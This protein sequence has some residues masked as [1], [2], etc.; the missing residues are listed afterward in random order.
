MS[1]VD[2]RAVRVSDAAAISEIYAYYVG[3]TAISFEYAAPD[4]DEIARRIAVTTEKYP[5]I[6]AEIDGKVIGYAYASPLGERAAYHR[7]AELSIYIAAAERGFG[8]GKTL[9]ALMES[10]LRAAGIVN[11]YACITQA[12]SDV[13]NEP[14][15]T[16]ASIRFH[17]KQGYRQIGRFNRCGY[18]FGRWYDTIWMEKIIGEHTTV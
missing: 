6:V 14:Y 7:S 16:D 17:E 15:V 4:A 3:N 8:I 5:Y 10:K 18:K 2:Y 9:Y 11:L 13:E 12:P 1:S